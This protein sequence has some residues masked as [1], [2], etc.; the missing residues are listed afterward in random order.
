MGHDESTAEEQVI[1]EYGQPRA[2]KP[3]PGT[4]TEPREE[5]DSERVQYP[6]QSR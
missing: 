4:V 1:G 3:L 2:H 5:A 6:E